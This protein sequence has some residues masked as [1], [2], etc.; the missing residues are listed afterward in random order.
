MGR[1]AAPAGP[2]LRVARRRR[3]PLEGSDVDARALRPVHAVEVRAR[4]P[5][6]RARVDGGAPGGQPEALAGTRKL[7]IRADGPRHD[8]SV[9]RGAVARAE[10]E[11]VEEAVARPHPVLTVAGLDDPLSVAVHEVVRNERVDVPGARG[12]RPA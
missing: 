2:G 8:R 4:R 12:A 7:R 3:S 1:L 11:V 9:R 10:D 5:G 6:A